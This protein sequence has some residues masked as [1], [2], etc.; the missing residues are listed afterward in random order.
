M[1]Y[2]T[3]TELSTWEVLNEA[4][5]YFGA[6]GLRLEVTSRDNCCISLAGGGG[7]VTVTVAEGE[8]TSVDIETREWEYQVERFLAEKLK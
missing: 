5:E 3:D 6:G 1:R 2:G 8:R 4:E 7:H